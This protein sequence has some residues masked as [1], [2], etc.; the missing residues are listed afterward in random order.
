MDL[1]LAH[2]HT[3][4]GYRTFLAVVE[5]VHG[6]EEERRSAAGHVPVGLLFSS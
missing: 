6:K 5:H 2:R 1:S 3:I 4:K